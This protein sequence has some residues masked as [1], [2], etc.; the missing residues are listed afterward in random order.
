MFAIADEIHGI[1]D[2]VFLLHKR[3]LS[4]ILEV[5]AAVG[6]HEV[7]ANTSKV[8]PHMRKLM[9]EERPRVKQFTIIDF[10]PLIGR[11]I[12]AITLGG[13]GMRWRTKSEDVQ[14]QT[15]VVTLVAVWNESVLRPPAMS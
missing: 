13:Q 15:F 12:G 5:V 14:Q 7:V 8:D 11:T 1:T 4:A 10:L 6:P 2:R 9:R 3:R